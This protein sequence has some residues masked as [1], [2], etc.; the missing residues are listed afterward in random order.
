MKNTYIQLSIKGFINR[1]AEEEKK[2]EPY[3]N[4]LGEPLPWEEPI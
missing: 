3:L 4:G 2:T 1:K